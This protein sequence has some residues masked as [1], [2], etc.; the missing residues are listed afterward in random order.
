MLQI[1][2]IE[3]RSQVNEL[4][5][6]YNPREQSWLVSDLRTKF[7]LQ[8]KIL[9]RDGQYIDESVL[10]ASDLWKMLLKRLEPRL[11]LVSDPLPDLCFAPSWMKMPKF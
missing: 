11:R 8:Q 7:E 3:N 1:I 4:F 9:A 6:N 2:P 10:R 5:A